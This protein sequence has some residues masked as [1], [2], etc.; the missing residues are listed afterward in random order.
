M[1]VIKDKNILLLVYARKLKYD[2]Y[3]LKMLN[4]DD[5]W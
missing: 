1:K 3:P 5:F 2:F 4:Y